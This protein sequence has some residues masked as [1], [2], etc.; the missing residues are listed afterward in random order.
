M[1]ASITGVLDSPNIAILFTLFMD[2]K[3]YVKIT[4]KDCNMRKY[5]FI[6]YPQYITA[7]WLFSLHT[8]LPRC[9]AFS[10]KRV[11]IK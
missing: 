6:S 9:K 2:T 7:Q 11:A 1:V 4:P 8:V 10:Y 5:D 3:P